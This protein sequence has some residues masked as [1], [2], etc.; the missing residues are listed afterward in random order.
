MLIV[1]PKTATKKRTK[2]HV[3]KEMTKE[4]KQYTR[5]QR[6]NTKENSNGELEEQNRHKTHRIQIAKWHV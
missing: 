2:N 6:F 3:V 5:K 1:I 4:L